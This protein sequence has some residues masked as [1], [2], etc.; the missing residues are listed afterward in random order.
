[1]NVAIRRVDMITDRITIVTNFREVSFGSP[2]FSC[3]VPSFLVPSSSTTT[4]S[5]TSSKSQQQQPQHNPLRQV[6]AFAGI[7]MDMS[8]QMGCFSESLNWDTLKDWILIRKL[9]ET[10]RAHL[11][12]EKEE[13]TIACP[14]QKKPK[15]N[16]ETKQQQLLQQNTTTKINNDTRFLKTLVSD[17]NDDIFK[18]VLSFL[19]DG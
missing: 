15:Q 12:D 18:H 16:D 5:T 13:T 1:M 4:T 10:Q 6:V 8:E 11:P 19:V 14:L 9:V 2:H 7:T 3:Y 17:T